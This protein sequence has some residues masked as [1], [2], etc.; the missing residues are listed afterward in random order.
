MH[1]IT[2]GGVE[3]SERR[4]G[5]IA[6]VESLTEAKEAYK[7]G[8]DI[9]EVRADL[10]SAQRKSLDDTIKLCERIRRNKPVLATLRRIKDG[11]KFGIDEVRHPL[12]K[13]IIPY[14]DAVDIEINSE[15]CDEILAEAKKTHVAT[16]LSYH[17]MKRTSG[18]DEIARRMLRMDQK[19]CGVIKY[20]CMI[21]NPTDYKIMEI[22]TETM[23]ESTK[24]PLAIIPMGKLGEP[25]RKTFIWKGSSFMYGCVGEPKAPGQVKIEELA[26]YR[27]AY[28]K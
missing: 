7:Q 12:F 13:R 24:H 10:L 21:K 5:I 2:I 1:H 17:D 28:R 25:G 15:I 9:I 23:S 22:L 16:F 18:R 11:G 6:T 14:A 3:F 20:A 8:A 26:I 19:D 4:P 27:D